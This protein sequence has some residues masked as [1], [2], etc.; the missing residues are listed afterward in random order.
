MHYAL[1][2]NTIAR[3]YQRIVLRL[4]ICETKATGDCRLTLRFLR[5]FLFCDLEQFLRLIVWLEIYTCL[6]GSQSF[7]VSSSLLR[8]C[9]LDYQLR[10]LHF[11]FFK[12]LLRLLIVV[13]V[14]GQVIFAHKIKF[15]WHFMIWYTVTKLALNLLIIFILQGLVSLKDSSFF[16]FIALTATTFM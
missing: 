7:H 3:T 2:A 11:C 13:V 8:S 14:D 15:H 16:L 12:T 1:G 6:V 4:C 10:I 9:L 5:R